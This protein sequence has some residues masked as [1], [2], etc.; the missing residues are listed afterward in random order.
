L[1]R[2]LSGKRQLGRPRRRWDDIKM[3]I[4]EI[5]SESVDVIDLAQNVIRWRAVVDTAMKIL[6]HKRRGIS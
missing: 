1:V 5:R 6:F 4:R 2:K 3:N